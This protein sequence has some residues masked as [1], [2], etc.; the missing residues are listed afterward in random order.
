MPKTTRVPKTVRCRKRPHGSGWNCNVSQIPLEFGGHETVITKDG[1][2]VHGNTETLRAAGV[3]GDDIERT[4]ERHQIP[5]RDGDI[6]K[7]RVQTKNHIYLN[8]LEAQEQYRHGQDQ[9]TA[10]REEQLDNRAEIERLRA[11]LT[12]HGI[13]YA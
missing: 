7:E 5:T 6:R 8:K 4:R 1:R 12:S 13:D 2:P 9:D 3:L 11:L 10:T